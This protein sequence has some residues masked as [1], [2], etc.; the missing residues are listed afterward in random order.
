MRLAYG[1]LA[2]LWMTPPAMA[3]N[4]YFLP[5]D[6]FFHVTLTAE[7]LKNLEEQS[8]PYVVDYS[9]QDTSPFVFCGYAGYRCA[10]VDGLNKAF[11]ANLKLA[12]DRMREFNF[13]EVQEVPGED[14]VVLKEINGLHL[15]LVRDDF[16]IEGPRFHLGLRYNEDWVKETQKFSEFYHL[17]CFVQTA[18][19]IEA[20][21]RDSTVVPGL[22]VKLPDVVP[23]HGQ[24]IEE[25]IKIQGKIKAVITRDGSMEPFFKRD[26]VDMYVVTEK[27]IAIYYSEDGKWELLKMI[28]AVEEK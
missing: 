7:T 12:Y 8:A 18:E 9:L 14:G 23:Q 3:T 26:N 10:E 25:P 2:L 21:W 13:R 24:A 20:S 6:A 17:G 5:G 16:E 11:V 27:G 15:F 22:E 28:P 1:L 19:A 4:S